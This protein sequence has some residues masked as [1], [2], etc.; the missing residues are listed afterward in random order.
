MII[1]FLIV[2]NFILNRKNYRNKMRTILQRQRKH[3][4]SQTAASRDVLKK[5]TYS[6]FL[7]DALSVTVI[8]I[9]R[10]NRR[11]EFNF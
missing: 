2:S 8:I 5:G 9:K 4:K 11:P 10:C 6:I 1:Y 7:G 3:F